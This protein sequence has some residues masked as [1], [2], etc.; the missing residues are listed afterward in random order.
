MGAFCTVVILSFC[1][2]DWPPLHEEDPS[3]CRGIQR[4]GGGTWIPRP[5]CGGLHP[6]GSC[7][8]A[9][10]TGWGSHHHQ[11]IRQLLEKP[12]CLSLPLSPSVIDELPEC[13]IR[14]GFDFYTKTAVLC[15][16]QVS[17]HPAWPSGKRSTVSWNWP[18]Y[19]YPDDWRGEV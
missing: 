5:P 3:W 4:L 6:P 9:Q 7:C 1:L 10:R 19:C 16:T 2:T 14:K 8:A 17:F 15:V 12:L 18:V 11:V 13:F